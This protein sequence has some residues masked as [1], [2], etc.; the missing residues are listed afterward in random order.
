MSL[1]YLMNIKFYPNWVRVS[2]CKNN[3]VISKMIPAR[4]FQCINEIERILFCL[5][6]SERR[7]NSDFLT[8]KWSDGRDN[9][10]LFVS[11]QT[12]PSFH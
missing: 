9:G 5:G 2:L 10:F 3:A 8:G 11:V 12:K 6:F 1:V 7:R 4:C